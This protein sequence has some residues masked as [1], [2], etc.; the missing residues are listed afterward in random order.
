MDAHAWP[1]GTMG[2]TA[3]RHTGSIQVSH[4][5]EKGVI[6][7]DLLLSRIGSEKKKQ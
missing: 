6:Q 1:D 7:T 4:K 3:E 2:Q 5:K